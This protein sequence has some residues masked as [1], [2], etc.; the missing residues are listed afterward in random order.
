MQGRAYIDPQGEKRDCAA[1]A[2]AG[3]AAL[4][5]K[6][7]GI[8][9]TKGAYTLLADLVTALSGA[10]PGDNTVHYMLLADQDLARDADIAQKA[11]DALQMLGAD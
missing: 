2:A 1:F 10:I 8:I 7:N 9:Q 4:G 11:I 6:R 3:Y 5:T